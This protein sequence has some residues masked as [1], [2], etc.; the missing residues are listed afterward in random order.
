[1]CDWNHTQSSGQV[2]TTIAN[3]VTA[4]HSQSQ[5][6]ISCLLCLYYAFLIR[7]IFIYLYWIIDCVCSLCVEAVS[8]ICLL[9]ADRHHPRL[10]LDV[11]Y[12]RFRCDCKDYTIISVSR[13]YVFSHWLDRTNCDEPP[14]LFNTKVG[15]AWWQAK[16]MKRCY[17]SSLFQFRDSKKL[18]TVCVCTDCLLYTSDA[19]DE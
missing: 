1:M 16:V 18:R 10:N 2:L 17:V 3:Y 9:R 4:S 6:Y 14:D 13:F 15:I 7:S 5:P 19:A 8:L 11:S 12:N